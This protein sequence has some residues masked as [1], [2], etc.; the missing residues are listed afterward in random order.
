MPQSLSYVLVHMVY[1]TKSR[2]PWIS[3]EM[4]PRLHGYL[5]TVLKDKGN[6]PIIV[7]GHT[8]HVHLLFGLSRS[9]TVSSV[10]E[11]TK[12]SSSKWIK[13]TFPERQSFAWQQGYGAFGVSE[14]HREVVTAYIS[15]QAIH[16]EK[17]SFQDEIREIFREA[18]LTLDER[19]FWD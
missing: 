5:A 4:Q 12:V 2:T 9:M 18:G 7:G 14:S 15:N 6:T 13:E 11:V 19:Y 10:A 1:G 16:H 3:E 17:V 8:D